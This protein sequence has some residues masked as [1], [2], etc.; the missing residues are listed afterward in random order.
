M[1]CPSCAQDDP[2]QLSPRK[3]N[4]LV[5]QNATYRSAMY[6]E[7]LAPQG[8]WLLTVSVGKVFHHGTASCPKSGFFVSLP[9]CGKPCWVRAGFAENSSGSLAAPLFTAAFLE[10]PLLN[11][12]SCL[13]QKQKGR[14]RFAFFWKLVLWGSLTSWVVGRALARRGDSLV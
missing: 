14:K 5:L 7:N 8:E 4:C 12:A 2:V 6:Y 13:H 10:K 11:L 9:E 1:S 3:G